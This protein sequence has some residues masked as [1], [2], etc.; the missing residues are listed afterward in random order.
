[1]TK[2]FKIID[3]KIDE[4]CVYLPTRKCVDTYNRLTFF[5]RNVEGADICCI[6]G[7]T[8]MVCDPTRTAR[9]WPKFKSRKNRIRQTGEDKED[10]VTLIL[11][12]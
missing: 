7:A 8:N 5:G 2:K 11:T 1:M 4:Y 9:S 3:F 10:L 6:G 12:L